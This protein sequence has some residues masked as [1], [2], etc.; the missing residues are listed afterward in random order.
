MIGWV[1]GYCPQW[2]KASADIPLLAAR[3]F[4]TSRTISSNEEERCISEMLRKVRNRVLCHP[5][6]ESSLKMDIYA[7]SARAGNI[8]DAG[9]RLETRVSVQTIR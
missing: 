9:L 1:V 4:P 5:V 3:N 6:A 8:P 2:G 7:E